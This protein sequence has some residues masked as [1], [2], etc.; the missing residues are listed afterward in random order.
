MDFKVHFRAAKRAPLPLRHLSE[1]EV[2]LLTQKESNQSFPRAENSMYLKDAEG[3]PPWPAK[4]AY[5]TPAKH[6]KFQ[7]AA[8]FVF[9]I[10]SLQS[11]WL[12]RP[13]QPI[14]RLLFFFLTQDGI[15]H[16][17]NRLSRKPHHN[18]QTN[19]RLSFRYQPRLGS[20]K[21][22]FLWSR[23][24][25]PSQSKLNV[26]QLKQTSWVGVGD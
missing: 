16:C 25:L 13:L 20:S 9:H 19:V 10:K 26:T 1:K 2:A 18:Q 15:I 24:R 5:H 17:A 21:K 14:D 6:A 4:R 7:H 23:V 22:I 8:E 3:E 11:F 12:T